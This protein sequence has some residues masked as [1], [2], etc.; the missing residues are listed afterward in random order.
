MKTRESCDATEKRAIGKKLLSSPHIR[1]T[2]R[3]CLAWLQTLARA[4]SRSP[5]FLPL[6]QL[7]VYKVP[8]TGGI[9]SA[10]DIV[11]TRSHHAHTYVLFVVLLCF[12][13]ANPINHF[14]RICVNCIYI[15]CFTHLSF[16]YARARNKLSYIRF[17]SGS[18]GR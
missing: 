14:G 16:I 8:P 13:I 5:F 9:V 4:I 7:L 2:Y 1:T 18:I 17:S 11:S 15:L 12:I 6:F 10:F 3:Q